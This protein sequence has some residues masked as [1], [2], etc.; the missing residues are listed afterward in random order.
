VSLLSVQDGGPLTTIQDA[1]RFGHL[2]VGIPTSGP[3]DR[4]AFLL[5]NRLVGNPDDAAALECTLMGPRLE[6]SDA[7]LI[8]VTGADMTPTVNG[9]AIPMWEAVPVT[10]GD[11]LKLGPA[12][13]GVRAY[14]ALAGGLDTP[15]VLG[16]RSTYVRGRLGG[17]GGRAIRKG[18]RLPLGAAAVSY[19][20]ARP[21]RLRAGRAPAYA[22]EAEVAVT[23][24]PQDDR[25]T[26]A[27][28]AAFLEGPYE[29]SPQSDRMGARLKGPFIEHTRGHDIISDGVPMGGIQ[30]IGDGQPIVLLADRQ[31]AGGYTKIATVCSFDLP[32]IAQLKPGGRLAFRRVTVAE[33]HAMLRDSIRALDTAIA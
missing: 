11:V 9:A 15:R 30:V 22:T 4:E 26:P 27:G 31:S 1:G 3:M 14:V 21:R 8:A 29:L 32:R 19:A 6:L 10:A 24:G 23:L 12:R 28:I 5:A 16:S 17:I 20:G 13:A 18:D 25:F 7:R 2:R 33:A